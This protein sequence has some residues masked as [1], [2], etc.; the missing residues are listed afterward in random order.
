MKLPETWLRAQIEVCRLG[1]AGL[2][3]QVSVHPDSLLLA[4][5]ILHCLPAAD[6]GL[7]EHVEV[8]VF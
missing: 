5:E 2:F 3:P 8:P 1:S 6:F 7:N 4:S